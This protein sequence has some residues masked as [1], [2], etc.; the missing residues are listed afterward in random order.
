MILAT[1]GLVASSIGQIDADYQAV[2]DYATTQGYTL[3]SESQQ[4]LQNKLLIDLKGAG[5]W[6]KLD[7]F[8][9][10]ATDGNSE[11]ALIDWKRL[12]QYTAVNSPTFT[13]NA[14]FTGNTTSSYIN[15]NFNPLNDSLYMQTNDASFGMYIKTAGTITGRGHGNA[16]TANGAGI[17][18]NPA[19]TGA[20]RIWMNSGG[21]FS[22]DNLNRVGF[23]Q[24]DRS[25]SLNINYIKNGIQIV[26]TSIDST[27][28]PNG[29]L[30]FLASLIGSSAGDYNNDQLSIVYAGASLNSQK[31]D[32]YNAINTYITSL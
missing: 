19:G 20:V 14:G 4:I 15:A 16:N 1:H 12:T 26:N 27:F 22:A 13:T 25:S 28:R 10:F 9:V 3:P 11:F 18:L 30:Y 6:S 5:I 2:L 32:F 17:Y 21:V 7:T 31:L 29:N 23:Y 24:I 8:A